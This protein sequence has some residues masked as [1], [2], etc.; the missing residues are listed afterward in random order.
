MLMPRGMFKSRTFKRRRIRTPGGELKVHYRKSNP[1]T[2]HCAKCGASLKGIPRARTAELKK[3]GKTEKRPSRP[4]G[5]VLCT[6]CSRE[7]MKQK[8]RV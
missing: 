8:A 5:G 2:A 1:K 6:K 3:L 4:Y 7:L